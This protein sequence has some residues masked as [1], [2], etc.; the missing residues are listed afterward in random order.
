MD[1]L[2]SALKRKITEYDGIVIYGCGTFAQEVYRALLKCGKK[3]DFCVV[4]QKSNADCLFQ[5]VIPVYEFSECVDYITENNIL[6]IIGVSALYENEIEETL[7]KNQVKHY[8]LITNFERF[9]MYKNMSAQECLGEIAEWYME[10]H[11]GKPIEDRQIILKYLKDVIEQKKDENK[12]VFAMGA[13][14]PRVLKA[15]QALLEK[16]YQ[17]K[18][19]VNQMA[20]MQ[21]FCER[22]LQEM[23]LTY[24]R[25]TSLEEFFYRIMVEN[26]KVIHLFTN[27]GNSPIDRILIKNKELFSPIVYDEYD[28]YNLC[29]DGIPQELLENERFCLEHADGICNR[30]YEIEYLIENNFKIDSFTIQFHDYCSNGKV[31]VEQE[32]TDEL[33]ICYVGGIFSKEESIEWSDNFCECTRLCAAHNCHF[34][35]YPF[36]WDEK[37]LEDYIELDKVNNYF[38]LH[39]PISFELLKCELSKYDYGIFP[40]KRAYL[41]KGLSFRQGKSFTAHRKEEL[42]YATGNK[43]FDYLDAGLPIIAAC[44]QKLMSFLEMK[45]VVLKWTLE[46]Y[47]FD[48]MRNRKE[49]LKRRVVEEHYGLQMRQHIHELIHFYDLVGEERDRR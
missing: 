41:D 30:G 45:G 19:I 44:P 43:Y 16:G 48:A 1:I 17:I 24:E 31:T 11:T 6:V 39:Q 2:V 36:I 8:I 20:V 4:S 21:D 49:E 9:N 33:S 40:I 10:N 26:A 18:L 22:S 35:V 29:Y 15:A 3:P 34:H 37:H 12:I 14:T 5:N 23:H 32:E 28:I 38:H 42:M 46:E 7:Q 27:L 47:D 13:L 25:C